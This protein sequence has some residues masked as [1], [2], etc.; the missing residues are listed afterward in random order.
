LIIEN[1]F[2]VP[3]P[4]DQTLKLLL[5]AKRVV[6]CMPGAELVEMVDDRNWR[7]K[8]RVRLGP[9]GMDFDNKIELVEIDEANGVVKMN[10]SGRDTRGK[11]GADGTVEARFAAIDSGT[12]VAMTTDLRFSGQAAQL[13]RPNVVQDVASK[14]VGDFAGCLGQQMNLQAATEAATSDEDPATA[15]LPPPPPASK[16]LSA[17]AVMMAAVGGSIKRVLKKPRAKTV[18]VFAGV[19][20]T[21]AAATKRLLRKGG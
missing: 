3:G 11:G 7:A 9:V 8:M 2:E 18:L 19:A 14:L 1:T 15:P 13:G 16:P 12:R 21:V 4:P 6:P 17:F 20:A 5:D 10:V